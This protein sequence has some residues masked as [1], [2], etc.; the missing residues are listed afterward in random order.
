MITCF[1][2]FQC[3]YAIKI[4][5]P[6]KFYYAVSSSIKDIMD[7]KI[8]KF[9]PVLYADDRTEVDLQQRIWDAVFVKNTM[10]SMEYEWRACFVPHDSSN[11]IQPFNIY[12]PNARRWC[13]KE[14]VSYC[15]PNQAGKFVT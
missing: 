15:D 6:E 12:C 14:V 11:T 8:A 3:R 2:S 5:E 4:Y 1:K 13:N 10:F 9:G 7:V